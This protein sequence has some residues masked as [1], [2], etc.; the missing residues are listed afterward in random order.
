MSTPD[1]LH[2]L[3]LHDTASLLQQRK[4]SAQELTQAKLDRNDVL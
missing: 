3:D 4:L 1:E 2:Y